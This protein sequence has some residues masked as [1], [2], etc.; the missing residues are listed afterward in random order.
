MTER[1][2]TER[3]NS[4]QAGAGGRSEV[5][6]VGITTG[7]IYIKGSDHYGHGNPQVPEKDHILR[8]TLKLFASTE[9][10]HAV[11]THPVMAL[12]SGFI[13]VH[14]AC[15]ARTHVIREAPVS[16]PIPERPHHPSTSPPDPFAPPG[17]GCAS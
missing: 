16:S 13:R 3:E 9:C 14:G 7:Q 10:A 15:P 8:R 5:E 1:G 2:M 4:A 11:R 12:R 6:S 17:R